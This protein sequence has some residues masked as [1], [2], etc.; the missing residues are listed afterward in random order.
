MQ[1][2]GE[3][4]RKVGGVFYFP[5]VRLRAVLSCSWR[6]SRETSAGWF[7]PQSVLKP[8][9]FFFVFTLW[10]WILLALLPGHRA[11]LFSP[12]ESGCN[13]C[14]GAET[15]G[16]FR[17]DG[18]AQRPTV[19]TSLLFIPEEQRAWEEH[20]EGCFH[21]LGSETSWRLEMNWMNDLKHFSIDLRSIKHHIWFLLVFRMQPDLLPVFQRSSRLFLE[22]H[23]CPR[24]VCDVTPSKVW[25]RTTDE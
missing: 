13:K 12:T 5:P 4:K 20:T 19:N 17:R 16:V 23:I 15:R 6:A 25:Q 1:T 10:K 7:D 22:R 11:D 14:C 21:Y 24:S 8:K 2:E 9:H 3:K 18:R